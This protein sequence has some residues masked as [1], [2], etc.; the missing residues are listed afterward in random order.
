[1]AK[2]SFRNYDMLL[3]GMKIESFECKVL[4]GM[5]NAEK[6]ISRKNHS[7]TMF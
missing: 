1:M 6:L 3:N 7:E 4:N 5:S 2:T